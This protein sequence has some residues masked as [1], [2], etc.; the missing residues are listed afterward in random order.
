MW[1]PLPRPPKEIRSFFRRS[2]PVA[3]WATYCG[4]RPA[5]QGAIRQM[6]PVRPSF[7]AVK[8]SVKQ[9]KYSCTV[10]HCFQHASERVGKTWKD[11][12]TCKIHGDT[13]IY[14]TASEPMDDGSITSWLMLL[15]PTIRGTQWLGAAAGICTLRSETWKKAFPSGPTL[16]A[17]LLLLLWQ[18]L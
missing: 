5:F 6:G 4:H 17:V 15:S 16:A 10:W 1:H 12:K 18:R 13:M 11:W 8:N 7:S 14:A 2:V 9:P 3:V